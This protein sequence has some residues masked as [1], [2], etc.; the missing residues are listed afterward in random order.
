MPSSAI[1]TQQ[2]AVT[3]D[4]QLM[5]DAVRENYGP[6]EDL[7]LFDLDYIKIPSGGSIAWTIPT[8]TG[9]DVVKE[10]EGVIVAMSDRRQYWAKG[11]DDGE[12]GPPDCQSFNMVT[13]IGNPG[14]DCSTCE[15]ARFGS[16]KGGN[17]KGQACSMRKEML[18]VLP[19]LAMPVRLSL[20]PGSLKSMKEYRRQLVRVMKNPRNV[21]TK[22]TL[23]KEKGDND[24][25]V[26]VMERARD[27][28]PE[29]TD[30]FKQYQQ[31]LTEC[32]FPNQ[33]ALAAPQQ[34]K[35]LP[36]QFFSSDEIPDDDSLPF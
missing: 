2:Y 13:G 25:S 15:F 21:V 22:F 35:T 1:A 29:E 30:A 24:Y 33:A 16:A 10:F 36:S 20:S 27:L 18:I 9:E 6:G 32:F 4:P 17:G 31:A 26:V 28:T 23:R 14:G 19:T 11:V 7:G 34:A 8:E 12:K 3:V 5:I